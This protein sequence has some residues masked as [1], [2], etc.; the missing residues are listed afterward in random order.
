MSLQDVHASLTR[1][2]A[3]LDDLQY[4][5]P[6]LE[7][8]ST[9]LIKWIASATYERSDIDRRIKISVSRPRADGELVM[10]IR[11]ARGREGFYLS[12]WLRQIQKADEPSFTAPCASEQ[13]I[14]AA[15]AKLAR[16]AKALMTTS[17]ADVLLGKSWPKV[18][19]DWGDHR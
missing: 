19:F 15:I 7:E 4:T 11:I 13:D 8:S 5:G 10:S 9:E 12:H 17:L 18:D 3:F 14:D 2:F 1:S 6:T 16:G